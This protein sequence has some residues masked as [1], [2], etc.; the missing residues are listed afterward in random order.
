MIH[1]ANPCPLTPAGVAERN[2]RQQSTTTEKG[3]KTS[4]P[5]ILHEYVKRLKEQI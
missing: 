3:V 5:P 1:C 4:I 2:K